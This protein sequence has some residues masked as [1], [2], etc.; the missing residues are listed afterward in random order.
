MSDLRSLVVRVRAPQE[1]RLPT[2]AGHA[3]YALLLR[4]I[5]FSRP[6]LAEQ[7][8]NAEG[9]K[10]FAVSNLVGGKRIDKF[11]RVLAPQHEAWFRVVALNAEITQT[12]QAVI[13]APP[14]DVDI[15]GNLLEVVEL[16][17]DP[18]KHAWAGQA[19][20]ETLSAGYL[21]ARTAPSRRVALELVTPTLFRQNGIETPLPTADLVFGSLCD[22]WNA[23]STVQIAPQFR[24][25]SRLSV[26]LSYFDLKSAS[27]SY[28]KNMFFVGGV[29]SVTY[30]A[31]QYDRYWMSILALLADFAFY[32]GVGRHTTMGMG[33]AR[34]VR[35][36]QGVEA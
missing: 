13:D 31:V 8:H 10:P 2:H 6:D 9:L 5:G 17:T 32:A 23:Y 24:E 20:Y 18:Q 30:T 36:G 12:L 34:R 1:M 11:T 16:I 7:W 27:V 4:W 35:L 14:A 19:D 22:K 25:Y 26:A 28:K 29:G 33:Q 15:D 21:L 3:L